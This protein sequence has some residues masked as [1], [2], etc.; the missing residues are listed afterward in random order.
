MTRNRAS[1]KQAGARFN[2]LIADY[3]AREVDD[4]IDRRVSTGA[5]D[6][7]DIGGVRFHG[8]RLVIECK[9][10]GGRIEAGSWIKE[11]RVEAVHDGALVG[12]VIAKL[13]GTND[14]SEQWVIMTAGD[15]VALLTAHEEAKAA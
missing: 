7:G 14:P 10:Y 12:V 1:A 6:T 8:H 4:L 13:R 5:K 15:L 3:L 2:R 9:D 11:A